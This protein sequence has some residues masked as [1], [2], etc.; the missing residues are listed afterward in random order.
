MGYTVLLWKAPVVRDADD[1][2]RLTKPYYETSDESAFEP[3]A[4][5]TAVADELARRFPDGIEGLSDDPTKGTI[6]R[7]LVVHTSWGMAEPIGEAAF[8][9]ARKHGLVL[10][11]PQGPEVYLPTDP[12]DP[13]P[14]IPEQ[15]RWVGF[16]K[17]VGTVAVAAGVF[18][19]GFWIEVPVLNWILRIVGGFFLSVTLFT[20]YII[21]F[22]PKEAKEDQRPET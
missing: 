20:L 11:D 7:I 15:P 8:E 2:E 16:L 10:Y 6:D 5:V 4:D 3:S 13:E 21:T 19:L 1:A 18:W 9:L 14:E 12:I 22:P 17:I